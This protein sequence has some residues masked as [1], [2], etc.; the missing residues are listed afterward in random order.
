MHM[1]FDRKTPKSEIT[2]R[3]A[4]A[5]STRNHGKRHGVGDHKR[6]SLKKKR[7]I[8]HKNAITAKRVQKM[9]RAAKAYWAGE[10]DELKVTL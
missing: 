9:K 7:R 10:A 6:L 8:A 2:L 5:K 1:T 3:L 4:L